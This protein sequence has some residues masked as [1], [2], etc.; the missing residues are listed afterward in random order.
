[1][2]ALKVNMAQTSQIFK[3]CEVLININARI[4]KMRGSGMNTLTAHWLAAS[5]ARS[6]GKI[7]GKLR[8]KP[9]AI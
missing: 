5:N 3:T 9:F 2:R 4:Y 1:M 6:V 7:V 8:G